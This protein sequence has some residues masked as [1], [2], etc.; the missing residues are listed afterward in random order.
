MK[1]VACRCCGRKFVPPLLLATI[2]RPATIGC[3]GEPVVLQARVCRVKKRAQ[4]EHNAFAVSQALPFLEY[5]LHRQLMY[6]L[7]KELG[8]ADFR[9][10]FE[11]PRVKGPSM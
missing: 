10:I 8:D 2:E 3:V 4:G 1:L 6:K 7:R 11:D 9:R 5:D